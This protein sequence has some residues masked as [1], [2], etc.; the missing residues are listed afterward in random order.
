M[1]D[2]KLLAKFSPAGLAQVFEGP[3]DL[4][5]GEAVENN[6]RP[7][8]QMVGSRMSQSLSSLLWASVS[9]LGK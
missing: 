3:E 4:K 2:V 7:G 5:E 8:S 6:S 9:P 1:K